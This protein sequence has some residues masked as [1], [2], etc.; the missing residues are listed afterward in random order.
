MCTKY[1][2]PSFLVPSA[3]RPAPPRLPQDSLWNRTREKSPLS[4]FF[5]VLS[6]TPFSFGMIIFGQQLGPGSAASTGSWLTGNTKC[7]PLVSP[8][9][10][11]KHHMTLKLPVFSLSGHHLIYHFT[12]IF[13]KPLFRFFLLVSTIPYFSR[14][15]PFP[16]I[17]ALFAALL[18]I[19]PHCEL[20]TLTTKPPSTLSL[21]TWSFLNGLEKK[22]N[23]DGTH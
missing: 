2:N 1:W 10:L 4:S 17:L 19:L 21:L 22:M 6:P 11:T 14:F 3:T 20:L 7:A 12:I 16:K 18:V 9:I 13:S 8:D 5:S 23:E 15:H